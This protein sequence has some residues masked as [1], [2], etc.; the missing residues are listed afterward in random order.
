VGSP[1]N[2]PVF[3]TGSNGTSYTVAGGL[4]G[5][6]HLGFAA[7]SDLTPFGPDVFNNP[8]G[9]TPNPVLGPP[10]STPEAPLAIGLPL[11]GVAVAGSF[12]ALRRRRRG[13]AGQGLA[14]GLR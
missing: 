7:Q 5:L 12:I 14:G 1:S 8:A 10:A 9:N 13:H 3:L 6:G 11:V 4:D 2:N